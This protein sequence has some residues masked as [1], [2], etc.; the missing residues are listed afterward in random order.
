MFDPLHLTLT[1][2]SDSVTDIAVS[3]D[4]GTPVVIATSL[5]GTGMVWD[6]AGS[7]RDESSFPDGLRIFTAPQSIA[8]LTVAEIDGRVTAI[9]ALYQGPAIAWDV[10]TG[11]RITSPPEQTGVVRVRAI[12]RQE[13]AAVITAGLDRT[14][15]IWNVASGVAHRFS[16]GPVEAMT[17][18][19]INGKTVIATTHMQGVAAVWDPSSG[20]CCLRLR[21]QGG[22]TTIATSIVDD[23]TILI[24][25]GPE[26]PVTLWDAETGE[27]CRVLTVQQGINSVLTIKT[28]RGPLAITSGPN[29]GATVW[30]LTSCQPLY[31]LGGQ[32]WMRILAVGHADGVP[33]AVS[34]SNG[35]PTDGG[36]VIAWDLQT[37][38]PM[39]VLTPQA[40]VN[41]AAILSN[42][43]GTHILT[44]HTGGPVY[45]QRLRVRPSWLRA[46]EQPRFP[47][48]GHNGIITSMAI[49]EVAGEPIAITG[50][51]DSMLFVWDLRT[52]LRWYSLAG[53]SAMVAAIVTADI[54]GT[55]IA[56]TGG[57]DGECMVW[58]LRTGRRRWTLPTGHDVA[59]IVTA[60][61]DGTPIAV[62]G[63]ADG[64]CM[65]WDLRTG[66]R[67]W[68][69][70]TGHDVAAIVTADIDGTPIAVTGGADGECMVWDL[71][72]GRR[73]W[74]LPTGHDV[75]AIV[76][77]DIDGT[78]IAVTGGADGECMVWDLRT[79]RRRWTLPTGHDVAAIVTADIDG[80]PI[81]VTGGADGECMVWDLRTGRRRWTLPTGHDVAAIVTADIDGTPIAVTGGADGECMVWDL[82]RR[83]VL[84]NLP[85]LDPIQ[86]VRIGCECTIIV[87]TGPDIIGYRPLGGKL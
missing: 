28:D 83:T 63:G 15:Q 62:T 44:A 71:R 51:T 72:T 53:H 49:T 81:A 54:D 40:N 57:A 73:R 45:S 46:G 59:A 26:T 9:A 77:A 2:H 76:T 30:D 55:P 22:A 60:D 61:I 41:T 27:A 48:R 11:V 52:G 3:E 31:G 78:P 86:L 42:S 24:T 68:T 7:P 18:A 25:A 64:E 4:D 5:D 47:I 69:L 23:R 37:G 13:G 43:S 36:P 65:V 34:G 66:R 87:A 12:S 6:I 16:T 8:D 32:D 29:T 17:S 14:L 20:S 35:G 70:P 56:V 85:V 75:A 38:C 50:G 58:D 80:T 33:I 82:R 1:G 21:G 74:T 10:A 67:R 79:G 39:D 84:A 19:T